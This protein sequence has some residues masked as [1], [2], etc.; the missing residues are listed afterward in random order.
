MPKCSHES[1][2][3]IVLLSAKS[4][5]WAKYIFDVCVG[6]FVVLLF[7]SCD[8]LFASLIFFMSFSDFFECLCFAH[9]RYVFIMKLYIIY[10]YIIAPCIHTPDSSGKQPMHVEQF[11]QNPVLSD[12]KCWGSS[13][14]LM[15]LF[16]LRVIPNL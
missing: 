2:L 16:F 6:F 4:F 11:F 9:F 8:F 12:V 5:L 3:F 10:M 14:T 1:R 15:E 7:F 13:G